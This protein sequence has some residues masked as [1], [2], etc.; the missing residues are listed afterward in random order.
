MNWGRVLSFV[1]F[2][3]VVLIVLWFKY[4]KYLEAGAIIVGAF[5]IWRLMRKGGNN[6]GG[7]GNEGEG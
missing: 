6:S 5:F 2:G 3:V 7:D 1:F 4:P